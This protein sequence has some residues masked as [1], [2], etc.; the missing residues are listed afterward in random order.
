MKSSSDA[1]GAVVIVLLVT[2]CAWLN[3]DR[4]SPLLIAL[5]AA[6]LVAAPFLPVPNAPSA[7]AAAPSLGRDGFV[8]SLPI[9]ALISR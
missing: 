9:A 2:T 3:L 8:R 5:A 4:A 1:A 6:A 7:E